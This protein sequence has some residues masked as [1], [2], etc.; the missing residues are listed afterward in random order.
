MND[1]LIKDSVADALDTM[2]RG[3]MVDE[4][5]S[6]WRKTT[7]DLL[8]RRYHKSDGADSYYWA[9]L[10]MTIYYPDKINPVRCFFYDA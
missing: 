3:F 7:L 4:T 1:T 6:R 5:D 10:R 8:E 9:P 2:E